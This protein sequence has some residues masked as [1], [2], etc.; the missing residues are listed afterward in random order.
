MK[1]T[2]TQRR[3]STRVK[4]TSKKVAR[5]DES[6]RARMLSKRLESLEDDN[7]KEE[8]DLND[9]TYVDGEEDLVPTSGSRKKRKKVKRVK[10]AE[11]SLDIL[12]REANLDQFPE[13]IPTYLSILADPPQY[14]ALKVCSVTGNVGKYRCQRCGML[15]SSVMSYIT[16]KETR[17]LCW[18]VL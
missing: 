8:V 2:S 5:L 6:S 11:K 4:A 12:T 10:R 1:R 18:K 13:H 16:H 7:Y 14:P 9:A 17:C 3:K 15:F